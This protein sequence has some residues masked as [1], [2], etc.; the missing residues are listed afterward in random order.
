V[1]NS[2]RKLL[3]WPL[4]AYLP[5][6]ASAVGILA[7]AMRLS[8]PPSG[9]RGF[10]EVFLAYALRFPQDFNIVRWVAPGLGLVILLFLSVAIRSARPVVSLVSIRIVLLILI[11][12]LTILVQIFSVV[13]LLAPSTAL[14][15]GSFE[16]T[17]PLT[18]YLFLFL[19]VDLI[20]V[21][22]A[23]FLPAYRSLKKRLA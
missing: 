19:D 21:F 15:Q 6:S 20:L 2:P 13:L 4:I 11:V 12:L 22:L 18:A 8:A 23:T 7:F 14:P 16:A 10:F 9:A 5:V 1:S 3:V 17:A